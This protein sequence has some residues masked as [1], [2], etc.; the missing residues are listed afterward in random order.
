MRPS[1]AVTQK[2]L[3][4]E[5]P[6]MPHGQERS[7]IKSHKAGVAGDHD[8]AGFAIG[9]DQARGGICRE[10]INGLALLSGQSAACLHLLGE[11]A[12]H[13]TKIVIEDRREVRVSVARQECVRL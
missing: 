7:Q 1:Y 4:K 6:I 12:D 3:R 8:P 10:R 9:I 13:W 5:R 2:H 11:R